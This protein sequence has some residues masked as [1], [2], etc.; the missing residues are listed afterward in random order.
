MAAFW[1]SEIS[2][3]TGLLSSFIPQRYF[4]R[5]KEGSNEAAAGIS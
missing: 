4:H 5:L 1:Q 2:I 3:V